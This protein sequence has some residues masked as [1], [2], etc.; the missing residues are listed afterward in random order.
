[1]PRNRIAGVAHYD[2]ALQYANRPLRKGLPPLPTRKQA[3]IGSAALLLLIFCAYRI[4]TFVPQPLDSPG[5]LRPILY[6]LFSKFVKQYPS[7]E[8]AQQAWSSYCLI[9][10]FIP[11]SLALLNYMAR[12]SL[13]RPLVW[14]HKVLGSRLL[15]FTGIAASLIVCRF[16][17]LLI[18]EINPDETLFIAAAHKLFRD[19]VFF[20]A[21]DCGTT[22][23][24][25]IFP[26]M[27]PALFGISPD[28]ASARVIALCI[29]LASVYTIYRTLALLTDDGVARIAILPAAGAFACLKHNDFLH[30]SSEHVSFLLLSLA[31]YVCVRIFRSPRSYEW[32][33]AGLG[34]LTAAA[35]LAKMQTVPILG[36][37]ALVAIAYIHQS[38][39]AERFWRPSVLF[40]AGLAPLLLLNAVICAAA[41]VW[42]DFWME[43]LVAN[44]RYVESHGALTAE[45]SRFAGLVVGVAEIPLLLVNLLAVLA[46]YA[47]QRMRRALISDQALFLEMGV[48]S[49]IVAVATDALLHAAGNAMV[50]YAMVLSMLLLPGSFLLLCRNGDR[51]PSPV[52]WF[53][54]LAAALLASAAVAVYT[55]HRL[56]GHYLLLFIFPLTIAMAWPVVAGSPAPEA[57]PSGVDQQEPS[58]GRRSPLPFLLIFATLTL[59]C[60]LFQMEIGRAHV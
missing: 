36:C 44:Y 41:G 58:P 27:L 43:Y 47:Y 13:S 59:V 34:L 26:L 4:L 9:A 5:T 40:A 24:I 29:I 52:R 37:V 11:A 6:S 53:G 35:F 12:S 33:L 20:R 48:V 50:S 38:G 10:L 19:P 1:M 17:I 51:H 8:Q 14:V 57:E 56:Y 32:G 45:L 46:A 3:L 55:P 25:N 42:H 54:F 31:L 28:Y 21:V 60:Q 49:G 2:S 22:G 16:P 18:N 23:P 39:H 7:P 30:Y 15:L